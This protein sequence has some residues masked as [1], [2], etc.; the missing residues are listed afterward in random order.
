MYS[1]TDAYHQILVYGKPPVMGD[2]GF[3]SIIALGLMLLSLFLFR[4][5][6][7]EMVDV[8]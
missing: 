6:S 8:L 1:I 2:I 3:I 4:R 7:P 5:A